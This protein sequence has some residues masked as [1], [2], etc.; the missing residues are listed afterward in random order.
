[1]AREPTVQI[2]VV[3]PAHGLTGEVYVQPDPDL[4]HLLEPGRRCDLAG[5]PT[6]ITA[7]RSHRG[8]LLV[9]FAGVE[10]RDEAEAL[11]RTPVGIPR[12]DVPLADD[13]VWVADLIAR[14]VVDER[15]R[16]VGHVRDVIDGPAHDW[17]VVAVTAGATGD[18]PAADEPASDESAREVRVPCVPDLVVLD[19][20]R[21][22]VAEVPGL[23]DDRWV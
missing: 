16:L 19:G 3:G 13:D 11:R 6:E 4:G 5:R 8:R 9:R 17:L 20:E 23:L 1:M 14:E 2:G 10:G 12:E 22:V 15:G 18:E 21:V 7:L